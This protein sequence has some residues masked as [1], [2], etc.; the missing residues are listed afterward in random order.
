MS[1]SESSRLIK[2][3]GFVGLTLILLLVVLGGLGRSRGLFSDKAVLHTSFDN[4]SGLVVGA[5]VRLAGIDVGI[6]QSI[7]FERDLQTKKVRVALGVQSRYLER[8][9]ADSVARLTSKGLL[10]DMLIN[11]S[12][13]SPNFPQL[14]GGDTLK[15]QESDGLM[16]VVASLQEGVADIRKLVVDV[17]GRVQTVLSDETA[18]DIQRAVR[19]TANIIEHVERGGGLLHDVIYQQRLSERAQALVSDAQQ[20]AA[21]FNQALQRI[22]GLLAEVEKGKGSLHGLIYRDDV[23]ALLG[24]LR[25]SVADIDTVVAELRRGSGPLHALIYD[26]EAGSLIADLTATA[27]VLRSL[28]EDAQQGKGTVGGLLQDPTVYQDLKL[29]VGNV[30]RSALLKALIRTAIRSDGLKRG[31]T[32]QPR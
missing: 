28:A 19:S 18:R 30:Q 1:N 25:Q 9:R 17:D 31:P 21:R 13:G 32:S 20:G 4:I 5:P 2:V 27:R 16:E 3:G 24:A 6:V 7:R 12:V 11:I 23:G 22:D 10:G 29:I 26:K 15:A 8:I 14:H